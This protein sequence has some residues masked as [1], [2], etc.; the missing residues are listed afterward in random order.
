MVLF[1]TH[2]LKKVTSHTSKGY[3][4]LKSDTVTLVHL[5]FKLSALSHINEDIGTWYEHGYLNAD[6]G[7]MIR[8]EL[9]KCLR[10]LKRF[11]ARITDLLPPKDVFLDSMIAPEDG[12]LYGSIVNRLYHVPD[13]FTRY[14]NW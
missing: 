8:D 4:S 10:E 12:D 13:T 1:D 9:K 6:H 7:E 2:F 14:S 5:L 3:I 11:A